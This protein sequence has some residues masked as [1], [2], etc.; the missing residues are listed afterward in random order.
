MVIQYRQCALD[1]ANEHHD[2]WAKGNDGSPVKHTW[3]PLTESTILVLT[4]IIGTARAAEYAAR[5]VEDIETA[6]NNP[7]LQIIGF[8]DCA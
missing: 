1:E 2:L 6:I 8:V 5:P 4:N 3:E 7:L